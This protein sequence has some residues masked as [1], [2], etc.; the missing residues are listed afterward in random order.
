MSTGHKETT[1]GPE[2]A[3]R[4]TAHGERKQTSVAVVQRKNDFIKT[5]CSY[6]PLNIWKG[7]LKTF[8]SRLKQWEPVAIKKKKKLC[9]LVPITT[10]HQ[11]DYWHAAAFSTRSVGKK[12]TNADHYLDFI[13]LVN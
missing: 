10:A 8:I 4:T 3:K 12:D 13:V 5:C 7:F 1:N 2:S 11:S 6:L 9:G